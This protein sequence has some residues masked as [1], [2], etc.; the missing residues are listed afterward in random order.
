MKK[1]VKRRAAKPKKRKQAKKKLRKAITKKRPVKKTQKVVIAVQKN[2]NKLTKLPAATKI[3]GYKI[4][5]EDGAPPLKVCYR[6]NLRYVLG[7]TVTEK[8]YNSDVTRSCGAGLNVST[9]R[10][11]KNEYGACDDSTIM[12]YF[13]DKLITVEFSPKDIV[14]I[15][16]NNEGKFR[17]KKLKVVKEKITGV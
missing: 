10:W 16:I 9:Q 2:L 1:K 6:P 15:P 3:H 7:K 5:R 13:G 11:I 8:T 17:V 12:A 4:V 14:C